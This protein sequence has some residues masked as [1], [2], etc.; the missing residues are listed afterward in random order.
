MLLQTPPVCSFFQDLHTTAHLGIHNTTRSANTWVFRGRRGWTQT[1]ARR[2]YA[3]FGATV[4]VR[5]LDLLWAR[6]CLAPSP[7][8]GRPP[9]PPDRWA[10]RDALGLLLRLSPSARTRGPAATDASAGPGRAAPAAPHS[11][12]PRSGTWQRLSSSA[13]HRSSSSSTATRDAAASRRPAAIA[14]AVLTA[15]RRSSQAPRRQEGMRRARA[16]SWGKEERSGAANRT[17]ENFPPLAPLTAGTSAGN[18]GEG[19]G[20]MTSAQPLPQRSEGARGQVWICP[21]ER[22]GRACALRAPYRAGGWAAVSLTV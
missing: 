8:P 5:G 13:R 11:H 1:V 19:R 20:A 22:R 9:A 4:R 14:G 17:N 6:G 10:P 2:R 21:P 15:P 16:R 3:C 18:H 12:A 7:L